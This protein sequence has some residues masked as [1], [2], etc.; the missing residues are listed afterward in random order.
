MSTPREDGWPTVSI[1]TPTYNR[2]GL[3]RET[4]E[5]VLAQD[6]PHIEYLVFDDGSKD[7]TRKLLESYGD[8]LRWVSRPNAGETRTVNEAFGL[9]KGDLVGVINSDDPLLPGAVRQLVECWRAH[10]GAVGVYPDWATIDEQHRFVCAERMPDYDLVSMLNGISWALGPGTFFRRD[11]LERIGRRDPSLVYCGD[12]EFWLRLAAA[13]PIA[14]LPRVLATHRVHGESASLSQLGGRFA[15]EWVRVYRRALARPELPPEVARQRRR[16]L[17]WVHFQA[18]RTYCG[19]S[20]LTAANLFAHAA[21]H[22]GLEIVDRV[23]RNVLPP[24][25]KLRGV[26]MR[27]TTRGFV[28]LFVRGQRR[29]LGLDGEASAP[30]PVAG[31]F[32]VSTRYVPPAWSGQAVVFG[33]LLAGL[34]SERYV[35]V[36]RPPP[37][38]KNADFIER[39]PGKL[40]DLPP[41][42]ALPLAH[43]FW[44]IAVLNIALAALQRGAAIARALRDE[45]IETIIGCSGDIADPPAAFIASRILGCRLALYFF[46]DYTEQ[47][48]AEPRLR[49]A[50][51][52]IE[53][54]IAP[55]ADVLLSPNE[56]MRDELRRRYGRGSA[57]VRNPAPRETLPPAEA[58]RGEEFRL[59][60]TGAVYHLN[61]DVLRTVLKAIGTLSAEEGKPVRLHVYSAQREADMARQGLGGPHF[62]LHPHLPTGEA[63]RVQREGDLMLIPFSFTPAARGLVERSA[64]AKLADYLHAGRPIL[65]LCPRQSFL[66]EYL[67]CHDCGLIVDSDDA[68]AV[69]DAI[70]RVRDEPGLAERLGANAA[71]RAREDFDPQRAQAALLEALAVP[72]RPVRAP[73]PEKPISVVQVSG[74]DTLGV[75][76]NGYLLHEYLRDHG[77]RSRMLVYRKLS[78]D[79]DVAEIGG[80]VARSVNLAADAAQRALSLHCVLPVLSRSLAAHPWLERADIVHLQLIHNAQFFSVLGLPALSTRRRVVLSIHDMFLMTGH[81]V[82]SMGCE[83]WQHGCGECPDLELPF[84]I[85]FD[86]SALGWAIKRRAFERSSLDL[87]VGSPWQRERVAKSPLLSRFPVHYVPYGVDTRV[88][89][90]RDRRACREELGIPQ[91]AHVI[92]FR[93]IASRKSFKGTEF[94]ERALSSLPEGRE[95]WLLTFDETGGLESLRGRYRFI[96]FGW[97]LDQEVVARALNATDVFLMPST[98]EAFGLMAIEAM[99]CGTPVIVF[100]GTALPETVGAP[101]SGIAVPPDAG[102]LAGAITRV[103]GDP[104]LRARLRENGLRHVRERHGFEDYARRYLELYQSLA[105]EEPR[106]AAA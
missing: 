20:W 60:F 22:G 19:R 7:D 27:A 6:Y 69:A 59:V 103:L 47:W 89:R 5:S 81:C 104:A 17:F 87:V 54:A 41:E 101:E 83:R 38:G 2:A 61:Y 40:L 77:H 86:T 96:E 44:P 23:A 29:K 71:A 105:A 70:R 79:P 33:R 62:V 48:W 35:L 45:R 31:R 91:D 63:Q 28:G 49:R 51:A 52:A 1:I 68:A 84:T 58:G 88:F 66:G 65:A 100:E 53:R 56:K 8:R 102:A 34:P 24:L 46:D 30:A 98:A 97:M 9:V 18:A 74:F 32:A 94:V 78:R 76:V 90:E 13:G 21:W 92:A 16:N 3:L 67:E 72:G 82:Y 80:A 10:P 57:V 55:G 39:L 75:Q 93:S 26:V 95:T 14:H 37:Q 15:R 25:R 12:M 73:A 64:T 50:V 99:A 36:R 106:R 42:R 43:R 4:I 85:R 11:V